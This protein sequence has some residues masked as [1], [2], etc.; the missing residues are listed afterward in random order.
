MSHDEDDEMDGA[1][2]ELRGGSSDFEEAT[3]SDDDDSVFNE[4]DYSDK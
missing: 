2:N 3:V 4:D 1:G